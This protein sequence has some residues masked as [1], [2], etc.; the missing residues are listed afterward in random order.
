M[1]QASS[2]IDSS[3]AFTSN[4]Y[5]VNAL[6]KTQADSITRATGASVEAIK[7]N[8]RARHHTIDPIKVF[9]REG[10]AMVFDGHYRYQAFVELGLSRV[11]ILYI[12]ENQLKLY[13]VYD[14][15]KKML[16]A[17]YK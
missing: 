17:A 15:A 12:H 8:I 9:V 13:A 11:P 4:S 3:P 5:N 14:T 16:K 7:N 1:L 6:F 2:Q 10:M